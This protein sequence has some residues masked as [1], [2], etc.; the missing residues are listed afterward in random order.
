LF[1]SLNF[2]L[3]AKILQTF[4]ILHLL[5]SKKREQNTTFLYI[6]IYIYTSIS[7]DLLIGNFC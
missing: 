4:D 3:S 5:I 2:N 6:Y 1:L 7:A